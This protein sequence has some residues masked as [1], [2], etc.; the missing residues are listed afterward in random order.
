M[1]KDRACLTGARELAIEHAGIRLE[2]PGDDKGWREFGF[3][4]GE[5]KSGRALGQGE[6]ALR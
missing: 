2:L 1:T 6:G 5:K 3:R 4:E